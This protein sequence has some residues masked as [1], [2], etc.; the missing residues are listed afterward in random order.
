MK[1]LLLSIALALLT[2]TLSAQKSNYE[3]YWQAREDS[4]TKSQTTLGNGATEK[5]VTS[6]KPEYDDLYYQPSTG[7]IILNRYCLKRI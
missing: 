4:I 6:V 1:K 2:F 5:Q 7:G 3:K